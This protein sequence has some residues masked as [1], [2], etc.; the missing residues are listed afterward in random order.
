MEYELIVGLEFFDFVVVIVSG[1]VGDG[2]I[3]YRS[4]LCAE[5]VS[6]STQRCVGNENCIAYDTLRI[7]DILNTAVL[8]STAGIIDGPVGKKGKVHPSP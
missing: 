2:L 4:L 3:A 7:Y 1:L 5:S 6:T 8:V